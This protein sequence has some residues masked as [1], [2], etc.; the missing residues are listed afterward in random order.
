MK[1]F[2]FTSFDPDQ[3]PVKDFHALLLGAVAPRPIAFVSTTDADGNVNLAPFSFFNVFGS[4][5][6][7]LIFSPANRVR[8]NT[9]KHTLENVREVPEAVVSLVSYEMAEQM[10]M[11][12]A[13][14]DKGV[15]EYI[16]A[17]F[18][19][20]ASEKVK[21]PRVGEAPVSFECKVFEIKTVG[22]GGGSANLVLC[23]VLMAHFHSELVNENAKLNLPAFDLVGR[24]GGD[25]Y[26]R[27]SGEALFVLPKTPL[28]KGMGFDALPEPVLNSSV[29]TGRHLARLANQ[30]R[31][32]DSTKISQ[33]AELPEIAALLIEY[34]NDLHALRNNLQQIA[35]KKLDEGMPDDAW[36]ILLQDPGLY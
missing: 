21:P 10:S 27:A 8:D 17:G 36:A 5:P 25:Y 16:K 35:S 1:S 18:T 29:L 20:V 13:E 7:L 11:A 22:H 33:I 14:Y 23:E 2:E 9:G 30:E 12:G 28:Q 3:T 32:P 31:L 19:Q 15:N 34:N 26:V 6:P 4:K 24:M